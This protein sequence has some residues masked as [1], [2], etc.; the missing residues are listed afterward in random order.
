M[1]KEAIDAADVIIFALGAKN[2]DFTDWGKRILNHINQ[3]RQQTAGK[4]FGILTRMDE[5]VDPAEYKRCRHIATVSLLW[6]RFRQNLGLLSQV[7]NSRF[8]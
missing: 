6:L 5:C 3:E 2:P 4:A 7:G 8:E 1:T